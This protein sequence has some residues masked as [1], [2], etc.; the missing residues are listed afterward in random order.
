MSVELNSSDTDDA[1]GEL[2]DDVVASVTVQERGGTVHVSIPK[3]GALDLGLE[4][5][6]NV[7]FTGE[8]GDRSLQLKPSGTVLGD[9]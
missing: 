8:Q 3:Q 7:L 9:E 4:K 2:T 1:P 6:D 5:G